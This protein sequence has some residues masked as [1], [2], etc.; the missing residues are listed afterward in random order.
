MNGRTSAQL[1]YAILLYIE[2]MACGVE[3]IRSDTELPCERQGVV[4][5]FL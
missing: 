5:V 2:S 1:F 3:C 4:L